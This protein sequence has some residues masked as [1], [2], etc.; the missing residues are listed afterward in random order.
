MRVVFEISWGSEFSRS[1]RSGENRP[2]RGEGVRASVERF[3]GQGMDIWRTI[4]DKIGR[5]VSRGEIG[6][7]I[8][9]ESG[10]GMLLARRGRRGSI[11]VLVA[12]TN[13]REIVLLQNARRRA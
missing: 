6:A 7:G 10:F 2:A 3:R 5:C 4:L 9:T 8:L 13:G 12:E 11:V 1:V